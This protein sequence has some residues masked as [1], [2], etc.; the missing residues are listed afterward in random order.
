MARSE[1]QALA[2]LG[3]ILVPEFHHRGQYKAIFCG[4]GEGQALAQLGRNLVPGF[5][6][7]GQC[8]AFVLWRGARAMPWLS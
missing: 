1:G 5:N 4:A 3:R 8:K 7:R 6:H 2:Q